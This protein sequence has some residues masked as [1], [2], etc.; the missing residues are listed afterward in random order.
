MISIKYVLQTLTEAPLTGKP[1]K[2]MFGFRELEFLAHV[3][4]NGEVRPI[5]KKDRCNQK[6]ACTTSK[7]Q[8]WSLIGMVGFKK[9]N[10]SFCKGFSNSY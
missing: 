3:A 4:G 2:C 9:M 7:K 10:F 5:Q 1:N 8:V 6:Y